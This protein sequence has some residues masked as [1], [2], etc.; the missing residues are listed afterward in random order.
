MLS[1]P[2]DRLDAQEIPMPSA[3]PSD[4]TDQ[5]PPGAD[6]RP[7]RPSVRRRRLGRPADRR[8]PDPDAPGSSPSLL[9]S[10]GV[11]AAFGLR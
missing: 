7:A 10:I 4:A 5:L 6:D 9:V 2:P 8:D 3:I 1:S 11:S